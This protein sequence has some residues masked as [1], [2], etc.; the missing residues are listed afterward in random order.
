VRAYIGHSVLLKGIGGFLVE[1]ILSVVGFATPLVA[2]PT[3]THL[4]PI[5][6]ATRIP[7]L[8]GS[9]VPPRTGG[10]GVTTGL[11]ALLGGGM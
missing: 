8:V 1:Q 5:I 10:A 4:T 11:L 2:T 3:A 7:F 6:H 9:I